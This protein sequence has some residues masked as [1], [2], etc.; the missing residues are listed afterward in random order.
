MRI[1]FGYAILE[2]TALIVRRA[3]PLPLAEAHPA[4]TRREA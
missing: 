3:D 2:Q 4:A 1:M